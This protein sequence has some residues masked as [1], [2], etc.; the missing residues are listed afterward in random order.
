MIVN[1]RV[2]FWQFLSNSSFPGHAGPFI[3]I[4]GIVHNLPMHQ[5]IFK[6]QIILQIEKPT[7]AQKLFHV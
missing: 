4:H 6:E 1:V 5:L 7:V 3:N 2:M